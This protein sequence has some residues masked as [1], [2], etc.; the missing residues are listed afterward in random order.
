MFNVFAQRLGEKKD[1][2]VET[3]DLGDRGRK[4]NHLHVWPGGGGVLW[5]AEGGREGIGGDGGGGGGGGG[6][7]AVSRVTG[8]LRAHYRC[9]PWLKSHWP[10]SFV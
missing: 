6:G 7:V 9:L 3:S 2:K 4:T 1:S 8:E 10:L 5:G